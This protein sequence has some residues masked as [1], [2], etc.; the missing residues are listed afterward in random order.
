[1]ATDQAGTAGLEP[2]DLAF[3]R[4]TKKPARAHE[5]RKSSVWRDDGSES[6]TVSSWECC[7]AANLGKTGDAIVQPLALDYDLSQL[8]PDNKQRHEVFVDFFGQFLFWLRNGALKTSR[9][10]VETAAAREKLG[11]VRRRYYEDVARLPPEQREAALR[12]VEETLN[13]FAER[14]VHLLGDEGTDARIGSRHAYRLR[15][16]LEVVD[17]ETGTVVDEEV[18]N[19][20]GAYFGR[21]W[22]RWLNLYSSGNASPE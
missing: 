4:R 2:Q 14:L 1:M 13:S 6:T 19:R 15:V 7:L 22:G 8:P 16:E 11:T 5:D 18:I 20:G 21:Y 3:R 10:F 9:S 17:L 12:L